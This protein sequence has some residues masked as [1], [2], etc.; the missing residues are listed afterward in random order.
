MLSAVAFRSP[1]MLPLGTGID[2]KTSPSKK[3]F[4]SKRDL[5]IKGASVKGASI[6][7]DNFDEVLHV[8]RGLSFNHQIR[9]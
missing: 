4:Q 1:S 3:C 5:N 8:I 9:L 7:I 6:S 2:S